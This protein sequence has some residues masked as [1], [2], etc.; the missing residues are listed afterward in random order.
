MILYHFSSENTNGVL[1]LLTINLYL[2]APLLSSSIFLGI[3]FGAYA[4]SAG[5]LIVF[6]LIDV[7]SENGFWGSSTD[8]CQGKYSSLFNGSTVFSSGSISESTSIYPFGFILY[9]F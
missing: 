8:A 3:P 5:I 6:V 2:E 7:A 9:E 1:L 4:D